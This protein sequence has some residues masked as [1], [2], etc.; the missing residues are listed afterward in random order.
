MKDL[1]KAGM[2]FAAGAAVGAAVVL[3]LTTEKGKE[4]CE[5]MKEGVNDLLKECETNDEAKE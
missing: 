3:L 2:V 4:V 5:K 1:F